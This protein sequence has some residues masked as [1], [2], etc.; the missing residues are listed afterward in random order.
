MKRTESVL[1]GL[2]CAVLALLFADAQIGLALLPDE[3]GQIH[4]H[5][6]LLLMVAVLPQVGDIFVLVAD[7]MIAQHPAQLVGGA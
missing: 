2:V 3:D 5:T 4:L 7:E 1:V 6:V